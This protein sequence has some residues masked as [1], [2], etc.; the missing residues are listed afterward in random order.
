MKK[1]CS[2]DPEKDKNILKIKQKEAK[3]QIIEYSKSEEIQNISNIKKYTVVAVKDE[4][5]IEEIY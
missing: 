3:S 2:F 4:L 1:K 5:F